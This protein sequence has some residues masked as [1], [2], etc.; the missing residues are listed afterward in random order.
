MK[1]A[2]VVMGKWRF[3][4]LATVG[5]ALAVG[6]GFW[7]P[8]KARADKGVKELASTPTIISSP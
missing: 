2:R 6:L 8:I 1:V 4:Y 5:A 7:N 3:V